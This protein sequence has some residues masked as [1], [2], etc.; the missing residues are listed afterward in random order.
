M[1]EWEAKYRALAAGISNPEY[2]ENA[3]QV[4][5]QAYRLAATTVIPFEHAF[6]ALMEV[7]TWQSGRD[8]FRKVALRDS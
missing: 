5:L 6:Y 3:E 1:T 2:I 4:V 8:I 7:I